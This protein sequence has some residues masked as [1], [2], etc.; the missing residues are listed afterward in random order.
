MRKFGAGYGV[1]VETV[2]SLF[3]VRYRHLQGLRAEG[4]KTLPW[5]EVQ[6]KPRT[7]DVGRNLGLGPWTL[8][9]P[10]A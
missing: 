9:R 3:G 6:G 5:T 10:F 2:E 8:D 7:L 4:F 1:Q